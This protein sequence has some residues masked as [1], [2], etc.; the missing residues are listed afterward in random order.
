MDIFATA[1]QMLGSACE[2]AA[3][4]NG[5]VPNE[6]EKTMPRQSPDSAPDR[7]EAPKEKGFF[8]RVAAC[9][10]SNNLLHQQPMS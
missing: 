5:L 4:D 8:K 6:Q 7:D 1:G 2:P 9:L 3:C 10:D